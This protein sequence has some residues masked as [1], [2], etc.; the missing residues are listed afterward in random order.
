MSTDGVRQESVLRSSTCDINF[1]YMY[2]QQRSIVICI[3]QLTSLMMEQKANFTHQGIAVKFVGELQHDNYSEHKNVREG[4][5][6]A[7][8]QLNNQL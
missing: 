3:S 8:Y 1:D 7:V 4:S 2:E 5:A 6:T